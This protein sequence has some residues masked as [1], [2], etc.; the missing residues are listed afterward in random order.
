M[1][2]TAHAIERFQ[3]RVANISREAVL[4]ILSS[5]TM[6]VAA[7][8][9]ARYVRLGT[10]HR[11]VLDGEK[12]ITVLPADHPSGRLTMERD[13]RY[14]AHADDSHGQGHHAIGGT[15]FGAEKAPRGKME[16]VHKREREGGNDG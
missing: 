13:V 1:I 5:P 8:F 6:Q 12:V 11:V 16:G 3:Q 9:G 4:A 14:K 10:G 2:V 15:G 7:Q